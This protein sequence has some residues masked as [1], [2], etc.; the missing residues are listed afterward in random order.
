MA[1]LNEHE[2]KEEEA[3]RTTNKFIK[4]KVFNYF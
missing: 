4:E 2:Q 3:Y 1:K